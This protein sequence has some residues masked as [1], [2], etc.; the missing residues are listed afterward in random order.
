VGTAPHPDCCG[1]E[2]AAETIDGQ[3]MSPSSG[4]MATERITSLPDDA[5]CLELELH[6]IGLIFLSGAYPF[7]KTGAHFPGYALATVLI[8]DLDIHVVR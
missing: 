1:G 3:A 5:P 6:L 8:F 7:R 4:I 2:V